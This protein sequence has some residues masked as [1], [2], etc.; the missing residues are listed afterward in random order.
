ME[1]LST[2]LETLRKE[3]HENP[4]VSGQEYHTQKY[5]QTFL[6]EH[7]V[8]KVQ[9]VA[10]TGVVAVFEGTTTGD[11]ILLRA[12]IDALPI[13]ESN[14]FLHKSKRQGVSHKCGHD[15]HTAIL[16]GVAMRLSEKPIPK[17]KVIL[18]F[19]PAEE[20]GKGAQ[21]VLN[22]PFFKELSID[23]AFALH[24]LPGFAKHEIVVKENEFTANVRSI[25]IQLTGKTAH[26]AEPEKG[27]NP[28]QAIKDI[29][30]F[31]EQHTYTNSNSTDFFLM[32]PVYISMGEK[33]YG[34]SAGY[35]EI[36]FTL[37][38]Q[39]TLLM[40]AQCIALQNYLQEIEKEY[41]L[42]VTAS[43]L[44]EFYASINNKEAVNI[45]KKAARNHMFSVQLKQIPFKWGEDFGLFT[46]Q[47]KGAMFGLGA[48]IT[49]PALH[50][51]DY[52]FP[53]D[54]TMTGVSMFYSIVNEVLK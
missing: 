54:I 50:N 45:V 49:V 3:L 9:A 8:G 43:W 23:Y 52:D 22:D 16:L 27:I 4:E 38:S 1:N 46:Q 15:G 11:T 2:T 32:T 12:D 18:L 53:D 47:Y 25:I 26:A 31:A 10:K 19:Q 34:V 17:G 48:G 5:I 37:R 39:S 14:E 20:T 13:Q 30:T 36:H 33:A 51:P 24:N 7:T 21:A 41:Q 44:E 28:A 35:G 40:E 29:I 6:K 42:K